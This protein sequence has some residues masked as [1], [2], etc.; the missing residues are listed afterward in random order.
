MNNFEV[1]RL[2]ASHPG[3][4]SVEQIQCFFFHFMISLQNE[5][6]SSKETEIVLKDLT[7][8]SKEIETIYC[9]VFPKGVATKVHLCSQKTCVWVKQQTH[10]SLSTFI[11]T[12]QC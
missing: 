5:N 1:I 6:K 9:S 12:V 8:T 4:R 10:L 11:I 2:A 3:D 7:Y